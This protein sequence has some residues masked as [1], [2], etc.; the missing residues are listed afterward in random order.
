VSR[1]QEALARGLGNAFLAG[2]WEPAGMLERAVAVVGA[3][4]RW[5]RPLIRQVLAA[6][7]RAPHD[8]PRE[9]AEFITGRG[10]LGP[11]PRHGQ[12]PRDTGLR[13]QP[14]PTRMADR[15]PWAVPALDGEQDLADLIG[16]SID[17]LTW[18]ADPKG[19]QRRTRPGPLHHYRYSWREGRSGRARL[20]EAP[21]PRLRGI[22]RIL[23]DEILALIPVHPAVH[24]FVPGRSAVTAARAHV[25]AAVV[26]SLD[27]A[28]FFAGLTAPRVYGVFR[29]AGYP[30]SV[31]HQLTGLCTNRTPVAVLAVRPGADFWMRRGLAAA[32]LPQGAPTSPA[33]ANLIVMRLD[34]RLSGYAAGC[35]ATYTRYADDLV[36]SLPPGHRAA[37]LRPERLIAGV[38]RLV[39]AENVRIQP[40]KTRVRRPHQRQSVTGIVVND[41]VNLSRDRYDQLKA[42][43]HNAVRD[44]PESQ[45][46]DGHRD[47]RA[48]LLG[49]IAWVEQ[50]N[51]ARAQ[52]L[53]QSFD[54]ISW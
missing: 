16:V 33:L 20:L 6:Y 41:R 3:R 5:I 38:S 4:R 31:A 42:I 40:D 34:R 29:A 27:L 44:G 2:S 43:L 12:R 25:G 11:P 48:H 10:P 22:Q 13:I 53:R 1:G 8:R 26:I 35:G 14:A 24:G 23:L 32:H 21:R 28:S 47:F 52:R 19:M 7:P 9:L 51:P 50:L 18:F 54:Q 39:E 30:Q 49:R 45:N 46:R 15:R 36:F 37:T 17:E